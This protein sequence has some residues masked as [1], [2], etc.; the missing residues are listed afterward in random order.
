LSATTSGTSTD[1]GDPA[2][3]SSLLS[4][5][6]RETARRVLYARFFRG[7]VL[8]PDSCDPNPGETS[9]TAGAHDAALRSPDGKFADTLLSE[10]E[11]NKKKSKEQE[12]VLKRKRKREQE[13]SK[14]I[15]RKRKEK[16][17]EVQ[18]VQEMK[19]RREQEADVGEDSTR[20][21]KRKKE[22]TVKVQ[23]VLDSDDEK[24][25]NP[26]VREDR[27]KKRKRRK[28]SKEGDT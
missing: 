9:S 19:K 2:P 3:R 20:Q 24:G 15:S 8:G 6:K 25:V 4:I 5:A 28:K 17:E 26:E 18:G 21:T 16:V 22:K 27:P 10:D 7:P 13:A 14:K 12:K 11:I 1:T 23:I